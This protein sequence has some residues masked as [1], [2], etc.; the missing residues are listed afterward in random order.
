MPSSEGAFVRGA[1][2]LVGLAVLGCLS[3]ERDE[4]M[5][6]RAAYRD[7]VKSHP[8]DAREQC[9]ALEADARATAERYETEARRTWGCAP[10]ENGCDPRDRTPAGSPDILRL[11]DQRPS[12]RLPRLTASST[13]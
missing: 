10:S 11:S 9:A 8:S 2:L 12:S 5:A 1:L 13:R 3:Q 4:M 7:C 6:A